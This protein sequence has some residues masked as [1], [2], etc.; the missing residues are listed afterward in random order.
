MIEYT[1]DATN[2]KIGRVASEAAFML[3]GKKTPDYRPDR[4][5]DVKVTI[6]NA[7]KI[8]LDAK[9]AEQTPFVRYSG[10]PGGLKEFNLAKLIADKGEQE[11]IRKAVYGM[12]PINRSRKTVMKN[13]TITA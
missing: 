12:L 13:L 10:H 4:I 11:A 3:M 8:S 7:K 6:T 1:I 9:K 5:A 2:K